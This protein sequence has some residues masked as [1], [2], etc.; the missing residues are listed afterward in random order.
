MKIYSY[1]RKKRMK[2]TYPPLRMR[3]V[4]WSKTDFCR[5]SI[6]WQSNIFQS[7]VKP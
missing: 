4:F 3:I 1:Q 5:R 2:Y 7:E 6:F